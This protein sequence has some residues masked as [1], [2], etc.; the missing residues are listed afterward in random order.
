M[1]GYDNLFNGWIN[2]NDIG[3]KTSQYFPEQYK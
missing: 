3:S 1:K 2:A